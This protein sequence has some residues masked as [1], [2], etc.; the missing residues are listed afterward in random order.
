MSNVHLNLK[1]MRF[2]NLIQDWQTLIL[3]Q[4]LGTA[5][6][7][8]SEFEWIKLFFPLKGLDRFMAGCNDIRLGGSWLFKHEELNYYA[9]HK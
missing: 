5:S 6:K 2:C 3:L 7:F 4:D 1:G 8:F 9:R